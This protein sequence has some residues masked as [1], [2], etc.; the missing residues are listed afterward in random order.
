VNMPQIPIPYSDLKVLLRNGLSPDE[1]MYWWP[2]LSQLEERVMITSYPDVEETANR[3]CT[4]LKLKFHDDPMVFDV[5]QALMEKDIVDDP[6]LTRDLESIIS[7]VIHK[8]DVVY[9]VF[10]HLLSNSS[11]FVGRDVETLG[12]RVHAYRVLLSHYM[13]KTSLILSSI[14]A[15]QDQYLNMI[16]VEYF[17]PIFPLTM[18]HSIMDSFLLEGVKI[19]YRYGLALIRMHKAAIKSGRF[20]SGSEFWDFVTDMSLSEDAEQTLHQYAFDSDRHVI[21]K[22]R[23]PM[24]ISRSQLSTIANAASI[25]PSYALVLYSPSHRSGKDANPSVKTPSISSSP[26]STSKPTTSMAQVSKLLSEKMCD[27]LYSFLPDFVKF[28]RFE[29]AFSSS[30]HGYNM[31]TMYSLCEKKKPCIVLVQGSSSDVIV[32][33]YLSNFISPPSHMIRGDGL[34]ICFKLSADGSICHRW[35][36]LKAVDKL[37]AVDQPSNVN[38]LS[39][40]ELVKVQYAV[41]DR[42]YFAFGGSL[43]HGSNALRVDEM[44]SCTC[45]YSDTFDN[46][47]MLNDGKPFDIAAIEVLCGS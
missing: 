26:K 32:G 25:S 44:K 24:K 3:L 20:Q 8:K 38:S 6:T 29:L 16:F 45:G 34:T 36:G 31:E 22:A 46:E 37:E 5:S 2:I 19:I 9:L 14:G 1:R 4:L 28:E 39:S 33:A 43:A 21:A 11:K 35:I 12:R 30:L 27:D 13:P 23:R 17:K 15:L 41:F 47:P 40:A 7:S 10:S 18:C 42:N